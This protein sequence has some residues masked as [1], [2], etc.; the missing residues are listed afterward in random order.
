M[1]KL[2]L[3]LISVLLYADVKVFGTNAD[4]KNDK[5]IVYNGMLI[6]DGMIISAK[7]ITY[8]KKTGFIFAHKNVYISYDKDNF[9]LSNDVVMNT[10][11]KSI[12]ATPLFLFNFKDSSWIVSDK[13]N[14]QNNIIW[15]KKTIA[16]TCSV[17]HPD[18]EI[19]ST[20]T[21]YNKKTKWLD[22]YNPTLYLKNVPILYLPYLGFSLDRTRHSG[23]LRPLIGYSA[24]EGLL[25]TTP[26]YQT[27]GEAADLEIEPTM[28]NQRGKGIYSTF[29]F[30]HSATSSGKLKFGYFKDKDKYTKKYNLAHKSHHGVEF[31][32]T[33]R[34]LMLPN[35]KLYMNLKNANDAD[36]FYLDAYNY[37]FD[38][39]Y[40]S[41]KVLTSN[42]NYY[43]YKNNNYL[44]V[45]GKYF[46]DTTKLSNAD[47]MQLLPQINYH[48][49]NHPLVDKLLVGMDANI[50][51][52]TRRTGYKAVKKTV[53]LPINYTMHFFDDYLKL[54]LTEQ[55]KIAQVQ[56]ND[57]SKTTKSTSL[58]T[59]LKLYSNLS[60]PYES[61]T[62]HMAPSVTFAMNNYS[63]F[64]GEENDY[65]KKNKIKKS[66]T[67][68]LNQYFTADKWNITHEISQTYYIDHNETN[69][70]KY[71]DIYNY[72]VFNYEKF[73]INTNN[74]ID[75]KKGRLKYN[76]IGIG[77]NGDVFNINNSYSY[78]K[79][80]PY[81][82]KSESY[83]IK[84]GWKFDGI[85]RLFGEYNYDL[86]LKMRKFYV[87]GI[88]MRKKCWNYSFSFKQEITPIL[89]E[90]GISH[91]EQKT[92]YFEIELIP[93]GGIKQQYQFKT[94][95]AEE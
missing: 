47:T 58:D 93:L 57:G 88:S 87:L 89:T 53:E 7:K 2:I 71:S 55:G 67:F 80:N 3:L 56:K 42:I 4:M 20:S 34:E 1:I 90:S 48:M 21:K 30:V 49:F 77:Y 43:T 72:L 54:S 33:N 36:Y 59:F 50:Y 69:K 6:K 62:H 75:H 76:S 82:E 12:K 78:K 65:L 24:N 85:H 38:K 16:S 10:N 18:W 45:Y 29:R 92:I 37:M 25:L 13:G 11:N 68:N 23:F 28:R 81:G 84:T 60:K 32:Y 86:V 27:L 44:G 91:I 70:D 46:K 63:K 39:S 74:K 73:Y 22:L 35:D 31:T 66:A 51:N 64:V 95:K 61:F 9:I 83:D 26:Y 17:Q 5:I 15:G 79:E 41:N 40:L 8:N 14:K 19:V 52:Y 94:K